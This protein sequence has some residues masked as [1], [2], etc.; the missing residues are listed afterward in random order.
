MRKSSGNLL[1]ERAGDESIL[2]LNRPHVPLAPQPF[3]DN[4]LDQGEA[5]RAGTGHE[6]RT[7][8]WDSL[9]GESILATNTAPPAPEVIG[10][11]SAY[12]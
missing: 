10:P 5:F 1:P 8:S 7:I 4:G 11:T 6:V 9:E 2:V 12:S 3:K